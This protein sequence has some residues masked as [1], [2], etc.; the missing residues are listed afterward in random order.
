[1]KISNHFQFLFSSQADY[2]VIWGGAGS[3]KS[4]AIAQYLI[5]RLISEPKHN[6]L[7]L[8]KVQRTLKDSVYKLFLQ[9]ITDNNLYSNFQIN[10]TE[11][12]FTFLP[13]GNVISCYGLDDPEKLKSIVSPTSIWVEE[14]TE[15]LSSDFDQLDTRMR[16]ITLN[17]KEIILSFNPVDERNWIKERF[18]D[19][20]DWA[21]QSNK[22][23]LTNHSTYLNNPFLN[24]EYRDTL[25]S[26]AKINPNFYRI[27]ALGEW[28][29]PEV[30]APF[31]YNF[32]EKKHIS[33]NKIE[34]NTSLPV[35][36]SFDFNIDPFVCVIGQINGKEIN[37]IAELTLNSGDVL[38]MCERIK[39]ILSPTQLANMLVTGD[40]MQQKRE[41]T[42]RENVTA[43]MMIK[44]YF[45][46]S[47]RRLQL[48]KSNPR[49]KDSQINCNYILQNYNVKFN[50]EMKNTIQDMMYVE[51]NEQGD[52]I[53][54]NRK[55]Q[56]KRAD[57]L[58]AV[59]YFFNTWIEIKI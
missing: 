29:K 12:T 5:F 30:K 27:Y 17:K 21:N 18:F 15:F 59:R 9:I 55:N 47:D 52:I 31:M 38:K 13:N 23:V 58:D 14:A 45:K 22:T 26:R 4:Y 56:H 8:R 35:R 46:L 41:I 42:Q 43:W 7:V 50:S 57:H 1:M 32:E 10:K 6:F 49:I 37:F 2:K 36:L 39:S 16:G 44:D 53:K 11:K 3:G 25:E 24:K 48:L 51:T 40:A 54:D 34:F 28:G 20:I 33:K 19:D